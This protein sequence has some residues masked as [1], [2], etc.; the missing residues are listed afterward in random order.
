MLQRPVESTVESGRSNTPERNGAT[1]N[2]RPK[3]DLH[4]SRRN[5]LMGLLVASSRLVGD[6]EVGLAHTV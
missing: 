3:E 6:V 2:S 4:G 5:F 1:E